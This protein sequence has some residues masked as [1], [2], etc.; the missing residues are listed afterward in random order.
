V[1]STY[2][3]YEWPICIPCS[4]CLCDKGGKKECHSMTKGHV[5]FRVPHQSGIPTVHIIRVN[6]MYRVYL[7]CMLGP[8]VRHWHGAI[9]SGLGQR[10]SPPTTSASAPGCPPPSSSRRG[11][12]PPERRKERGK[13]YWLA[14]Q[15]L[16]QA[17]PRPARAGEAGCRL[18][19]ERKGVGTK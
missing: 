9:S 2:K 13:L 7:T 6:F 18:K 19:G 11:R 16:P 10:P 5:Y 17:A 14:T 3:K 12:M 1:R 4:A 15:P 8:R